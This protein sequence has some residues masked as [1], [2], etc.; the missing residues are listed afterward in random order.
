MTNRLFIITLGSLI[1]N[2]CNLPA[3]KTVNGIDAVL[4]REVE[5]N[6]TPSVQYVL[7][8]HDSV[9]HE[10]HYGLAEVK[11][12]IKADKQ[13][14]YNAFSVT[15]TF[16]ALAILQLAEKGRLNIDHPAKQYLPDFPYSSDITIRHLLTH[17]A[18]ISN[19]V[20]LSWIH[21]VEEH[22]S[23]DRNNFFNQIFRKHN[24]AKSKPNEK[25]AYTNLG[26]VLLGQI[27]ETVSGQKYEDYIRDH[28]IKPLDL[29]LAELGFEIADKKH[30]AKGY[31][32]QASLLNL[33]LGFLI[34]KP[35]YMGE[36]EGKWK[37][38]KA[39][40]V[41][42]APYG[43][44]IG[45]PNAL[46]AYIRELLKPGCRLLGDDYKKLLFTENHTNNGNPTGMSLS[47]FTG[48]LN[49]NEY[50]MHAGG[51]GGCYCEI[52]IYPELGRGS[53]IMFNRTGMTNERFL[54]KVDKYYIR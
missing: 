47:W 4:M 42:G 44:L 35:K 28:I 27:I 29:S 48:Q 53:V 1:T 24:K 15:K 40:Y 37:P 9:I 26:Y 16:T 20:P 34:D 18:G 39:Y 23:F 41:N 38:F 30:H 6:N 22:P 25:F 49:G 43:G 46:A 14:T 17:A 19:P 54:D 32:K 51:G 10:F 31:Q 52:R 13:T 3:T 7:F 50:F 11:N 45:T 36:T 12:Q 8:S 21:L 2:S 5:T 33:F